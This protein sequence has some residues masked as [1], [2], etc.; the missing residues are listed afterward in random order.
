MN[1]EL[2]DQINYN[3][4]P[5]DVLIHLGDFSFAGGSPRLFRERLNVSTIH[6]VLGNHDKLRPK[7]KSSFTTI[8]DY[9]EL[10]I[11]KDKFCMSHYPMLVWN[12]HHHGSYMLHGHCHSSLMRYGNSIYERRILDVGVDSAYD[13]FNCFRPF[14]LKDDVLEILQDKPM[15]FIDHH[16]KKTND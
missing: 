5:D 3:V 9:L 11:G 2:I 7:D 14:N 8:S 16:N 6:L 12:K 1:S 10:N 4:Q 13:Y 15:K